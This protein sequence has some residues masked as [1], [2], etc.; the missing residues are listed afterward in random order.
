[1]ESSRWS[2]SSARSVQDEPENS[3]SEPVP[4]LYG[5][6]NPFFLKR[7]R[8]E[9]SVV[10]LAPKQPAPTL[11]AADGAPEQSMLRT[12]SLLPA[13]SATAGSLGRALFRSGTLAQPDV[14]AAPSNGL[15]LAYEGTCSGP[16]K[17]VLAK[18]EA[19]AA[20]PAQQRSMRRSASCGGAASQST[21]LRAHFYELTTAFLAPF[22]LFCGVYPPWDARAH[23]RALLHPAHSAPAISADVANAL[24]FALMLFCES[25]CWPACIAFRSLLRMLYNNFSEA[26]PERQSVRTVQPGARAAQNRFAAQ[27]GRCTR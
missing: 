25:C 15:W 4:V 18:V 7:R 1:M 3:D 19:A 2:L 23:V 16:H 12:S 20:A 13:V 26:R 21:L 6:T 17:A 27:H 24:A 10:T 5:A 8:P 22:C 14:L 9:L 11:P